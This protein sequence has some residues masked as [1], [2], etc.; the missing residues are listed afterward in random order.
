MPEFT[1]YLSEIKYRGAGSQD[2]IEVVLDNGADP[3]VVEVVIYN[4]NGTVRSTN[5]LPATPDNTIAGSD[6]YSVQAGVH[7]LGAVALVVDGTV[8]AFVSFDDGVT[9]TEGAADG[10]T[11]TQIGT[12]GQGESLVST[13]HG[14]SYTTST[15]PDR[16]VI[17][18][19]LAGTRVDTP[20]GPRPIETL[21]PGDLVLTRDHGAQPV[22]WIG[23]RRVSASETRRHN[24]HPIRIPSGALGN[25][26]DICVSPAHRVALDGPLCELWFG[27]AELLAPAARLVGWRGIHVAHDIPAPVYLH[28][29]FDTHQLV[30]TDGLI[31]ESFHSGARALGGLDGAAR[32][33]LFQLFPALAEAPV[34]ATAR[35]CLNGHE[36]KVLLAA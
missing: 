31:S 5:A 13:D 36:T 22:A 29:M 2:F 9:A 4:N 6:V 16:G 8:V 25:A 34:T 32:S 14:A 12:T 15:T 7:R 23:S 10:L 26:R 3:S 24:L 20:E 1:P 27:E 19:F 33:E 17:P 28:L 21:R 11:S 35:R 30:T 18:C